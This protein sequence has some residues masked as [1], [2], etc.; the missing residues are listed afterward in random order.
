MVAGR[1]LLAI[2]FD[3]HSEGRTLGAAR[4]GTGQLPVAAL[5]G[6]TCLSNLPEAAGV[7]SLAALLGYFALEGAPP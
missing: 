1:L 6:S 4:I 2:T 5:A 3:E 7:L